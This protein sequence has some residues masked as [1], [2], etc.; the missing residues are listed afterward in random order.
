MLTKSEVIAEGY[1]LSKSGIVQNL[2]RFEGKPWYTVAFWEEILNN[3]S[4]ETIYEGDRPTE[5]FILDAEDWK[6]I[7]ELKNVYAVALWSSD[8]GFINIEELD[9]ARLDKFRE[10][11]ENAQD[12]EEA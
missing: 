6:A 10:D 1:K 2:G 4:S 3:A 5:I 8:T 12:I 11:A 9:K 7:P